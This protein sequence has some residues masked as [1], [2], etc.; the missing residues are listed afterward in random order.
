MTLVFCTAA[1][2][3]D[4][5]YGR[6]ETDSRLLIQPKTRQAKESTFSEA[7]G[8]P[9]KFHHYGR[10]QKGLTKELQTK[11]L[12]S[13][14]VGVTGSKERESEGRIDSS[15]I[16]S[17]W[18]MIGSIFSS[19]S[20]KKRDTSWGLT[21]VNAF[22]N[23][24]SAVVPLDN[25]FRVC[26][27]QPPSMCK[28]SA[29]SVFHKHYAIHVFPWDQEYFDVEPS[30]TVTYGKLVKLLSPKQQQSRTKQN[31]LSPEKEK[32]MSEP[33][34]QK[35]VSPDHSH[36]A[37]KA[38]VLKVVWNGLEELKNAIKYTKNLD[39][40]HLGKVWVS[41]SLFLKNI[42]LVAQLCPTLCNPMDYSSPGSSIHGILQARILEWVVIPSPRDLANPGI[43]P[44]SPTLRADSLLSEPP[45]KPQIVL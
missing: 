2:I 39:V 9:G 41:I 42:V 33:L 35:Q 20:E 45:G 5:P 1:L 30:F 40:L 36:K 31:V 19:G 44:G 8:I 15:F 16:P 13:N 18:T 28:A 11:Q 37:G 43:E 14:T 24:Q 26:K 10:D 17:L 21:E 29:T 7:E 12:Q 38:C 34:D 3:P 4:A 6:L 27:S 32:Q 22:K 23:M 25:I